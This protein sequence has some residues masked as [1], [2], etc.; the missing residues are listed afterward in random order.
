MR[1]F[2]FFEKKTVQE[3]V[4]NGGGNLVDQHVTKK[5]SVEGPCVGWCETANLSERLGGLESIR[6]KPQRKL[7]DFAKSANREIAKI[8]FVSI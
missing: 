8:H 7:C 2:K 5:C 1:F 4:P 3:W 6:T